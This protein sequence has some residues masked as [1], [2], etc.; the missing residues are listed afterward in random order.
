MIRALSMALRLACGEMCPVASTAS[1]SFIV[2][3]S[4]IGAKALTDAGAKL[5]VEDDKLVVTK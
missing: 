3:T 5:S 2:M 1:Y 4:N